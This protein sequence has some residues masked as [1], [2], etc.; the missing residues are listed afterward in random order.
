M[1]DKKPM[2]SIITV[3]LNRYHDIRYT[4]ESVV[5]QTYQDLEFIVIDGASS[6]GTLSIIEEYKNHIQLLISEKDEGIYHAMNKGLEK[7]NGEYILY[8]NG[9]DALHDNQ[10]LEKIFSRYASE[11]DLPDVLYGECMFVDQDRKQLGTRSQLRKNPLPEKLHYYSFLQGS[12]VTHQCFIVR[13]S[14]APLYDLQYRFS[15]DLDWMLNCIKAAKY[16]HKTDEIISDFVLGD[17]SEQNKYRSLWERF[18]ILKEHYGW[19]KALKGHF[20]MIF[21]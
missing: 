13:K 17:T 9:G 6:D 4:L 7:A 20:Q 18:Q 16:L 15:S 5:L 10:V 3:V 21:R 14:I 1:A 19:R 8:L 2:I 12:N 11:K